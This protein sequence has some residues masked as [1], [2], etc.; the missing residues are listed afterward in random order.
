[1]SDYFVAIKHETT[2]GVD[3]YMLH[4]T[5]E[6]LAKRVSY[7]IKK[8]LQDGCYPRVSSQR[9]STLSLTVTPIPSIDVWELG[10]E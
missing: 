9:P 5:P 4:G 1:M 10:D 7:T 8:S 2:R 3:S 6:Q